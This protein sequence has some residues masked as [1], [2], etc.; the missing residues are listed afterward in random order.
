MFG[1]CNLLSTFIYYLSQLELRISYGKI[2]VSAQRS[3]TL[4]SL[5]T[6]NMQLLDRALEAL[7]TLI[8]TLGRFPLAGVARVQ[9]NLAPKR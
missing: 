1:H 4:L 3:T 6:T 2:N 7:N 9:K 8:L 5:N